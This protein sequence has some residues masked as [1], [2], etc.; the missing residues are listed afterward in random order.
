MSSGSP[1]ILVAFLRQRA[2]LRCLQED[3]SVAI[4]LDIDEI[5]LSVG[6]IPGYYKR[7]VCLGLEYPAFECRGLDLRHMQSDCRYCV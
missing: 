7:V 1:D 6:G 3:E 5:H 4:D 2:L